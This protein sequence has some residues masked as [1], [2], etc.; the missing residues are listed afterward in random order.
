MVYLNQHRVQNRQAW[1]FGVTYQYDR[2]T[3][4]AILPQRT[5]HLLRMA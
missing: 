1:L 2:I 4:Y 5:E 3:G